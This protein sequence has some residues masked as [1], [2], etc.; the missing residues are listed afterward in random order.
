MI[1]KLGSAGCN[2]PISSSMSSFMMSAAR[3]LPSVITSADTVAAVGP[4]GE[5]LCGAFSGIALTAVWAGLAVVVSVT[6]G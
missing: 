6:V 4:R 1:M 3:L 2:G 5:G